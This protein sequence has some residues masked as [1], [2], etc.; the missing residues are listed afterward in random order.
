M[1]NI[2]DSG[3]ATKLTE[4]EAET[5]VYSFANERLA[6]FDAATM[7]DGVS[8]NTQLH[9]GPHLTNSLLGVLLRFRQYPIGLVK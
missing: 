7:Q 8:F 9:Q 2:I 6:V 3:Y 4:E 1:E 5:M